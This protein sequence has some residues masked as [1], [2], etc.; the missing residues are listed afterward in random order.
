MQACIS[1][2]GSN[3]DVPYRD[4]SKTGTKYKFP[5]T[6]AERSALRAATPN[7]NTLTVYVYIR[8]A[9][10]GSTQTDGVTVTIPLALLHQMEQHR[11]DWLIPGLR[12]ELITALIRALPKPIRKHLVPAPDTAQAAATHLAEHANPTK[13]NFYSTLSTFLR[14]TK[15]QVI[16]A[17]D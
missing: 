12:T 16:D 8:S 1:L 17:A 13:D 4:I 14:Q 10:G 3:A 6:D 11:F 9:I 7:S 5:L 15:H 2:T